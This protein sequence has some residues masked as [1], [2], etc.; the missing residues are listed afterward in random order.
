MAIYFNLIWMKDLC[1]LGIEPDLSALAAL[2]YFIE[3]VYISPEADKWFVDLINDIIM[4][5]YHLD[6]NI[7]Q[8]EL[9]QQP[10]Y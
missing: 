5:R 1:G 7:I 6:L 3:N 10:F 9:A 4:N 8:S 2:F